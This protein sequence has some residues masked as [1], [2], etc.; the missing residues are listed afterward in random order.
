M[1]NDPASMQRV[2]DFL[3]AHNIP[4]MWMGGLTIS[5]L[6][7]ASVEIAG[8]ALTCRGGACRDYDATKVARAG[9]LRIPK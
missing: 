6:A 7:G 3:N 4:C 2:I 9:T 1:F 8:G 5:I